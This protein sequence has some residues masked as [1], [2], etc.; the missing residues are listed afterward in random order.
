MTLRRSAT[1]GGAPPLPAPRGMIAPSGAPARPRGVPLPLGASQAF[2]VK[3]RL[4]MIEKVRAEQRASASPSHP[5][6]A[7]ASPPPAAGS[8]APPSES[9][10]AAAR[11]PRSE[12]APSSKPAR[13][14][15]VGRND[16]CP[17]GS[18]KKFKK[19]HGQ[20]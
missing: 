3:R 5:E 8:S 15:E 17:C 4:E 16:P 9:A 18:G 20:A 19:C 10:R 7:P 13:S 6:A 14:M 1:S 12:P 11:P 2:D